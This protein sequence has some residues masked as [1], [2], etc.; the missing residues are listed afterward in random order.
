MGLGHWCTFALR[1][2]IFARG[3]AL[4]AAG[5]ASMRR[6]LDVLPSNTAASVVDE[7]IP[8]GQSV[9]WPASSCHV[10]FCGN[11]LNY[12]I[13]AVLRYDR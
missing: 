7:S 6:R 2:S 4:R 9:D 12:R 1:A 11:M 13:F 3:A 8:A 10:W 5:F